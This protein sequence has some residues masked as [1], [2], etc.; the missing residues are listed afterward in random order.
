MPFTLK[1]LNE[2]ED[3][4]VVSY[5]GRWTWDEVGEVDVRS[6]ELYG[7]ANRRVDSICDLSSTAWVPARYVENVNR[8]SAVPYP[9][10]HTVVYITGK[11]MRDLI[12][13]YDS[14]FSRLPYKIAFADRMA[15][16]VDMIAR[17]REKD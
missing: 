10:L 14:Q 3:I 4:L 11:L 5:T 12:Q 17:D 15:D 16:A 9:N 6:R 7:K 8:V 1:W 2:D 13:T